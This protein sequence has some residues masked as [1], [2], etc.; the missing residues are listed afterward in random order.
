MVMA[1]SEPEKTIVEKIE[2]ELQNQLNLNPVNWERI[3]E[4]VS[5]TPDRRPKREDTK[6]N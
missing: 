1:F 5:R 4:E 6:T 3:L 2:E